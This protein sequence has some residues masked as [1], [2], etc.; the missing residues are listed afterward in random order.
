MCPKIEKKPGCIASALGVFGDKWT[1]LI[2]RDLYEADRRFSELEKSLEG[3]S[4]RTLSQRL[5]RLESEGII[6]KPEGKNTYSLTQKGRD[7][8]DLLKQ[9]AAWG[10][11]YTSTPSKQA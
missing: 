2:I 7:C 1:A 9:M 10:E 8:S 4:P 11:K 5:V 3:I 6:E